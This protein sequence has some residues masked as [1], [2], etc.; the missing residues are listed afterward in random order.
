MIDKLNLKETKIPLIYSLLGSIISYIVMFYLWNN[1]RF[2]NSTFQRWFQDKISFLNPANFKSQYLSLGVILG[3]VIIYCLISSKKKNEIDNLDHAFLQIA[4]AEE[5][6]TKTEVVSD[7]I[8]HISEK[9]EVVSDE[10][11]KSSSETSDIQKNS[12]GIMEEIII[13][14]PSSPKPVKLFES[15]LPLPKKHVKK[16]MNYAFEPTSDQM[17][18]DLNNYRIDDDYDL[19][20]I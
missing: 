9:A 3:I 12:K 18:Y 5:N 10:V 2:N 19:K 13:E 8:E 15:P 16:E 20:D 4:A 1:L 11:E 7:E 14:T 6:I 17:H